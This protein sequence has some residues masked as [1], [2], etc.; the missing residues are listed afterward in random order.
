MVGIKNCF[1]LI[2]QFCN[3]QIVGSVHNCRSEL[4][5]V[6][7]PLLETKYCYLVHLKLDSFWAGF[8]T[9][10]LVKTR[11]VGEEKVNIRGWLFTA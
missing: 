6:K 1:V 4:I 9:Y 10:W 2:G 3:H 7:N 11:P 8:F 5:A